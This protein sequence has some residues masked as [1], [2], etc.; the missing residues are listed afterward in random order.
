MVDRFKEYD[1][2]QTR[3]IVDDTYDNWIEAKNQYDDKVLDKLSDAIYM[4]YEADIKHSEFPRKKE[5]WFDK[6]K[7]EEIIINKLKREFGWW[8]E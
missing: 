8:K 4:T 2:N 6:F 3:E 1:I 7:D 5:Y